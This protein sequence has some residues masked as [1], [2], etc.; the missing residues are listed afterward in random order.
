LPRAAAATLTWFDTWWKRVMLTSVFPTATAKRHCTRPVKKVASKRSC[1]IWIDVQSCVPC[2][3]YL[4]HHTTHN[5]HV[6]VMNIR[7]RLMHA[8]GSVQARYPAVGEWSLA[9][10][11][12]RVGRQGWRP[13]QEA[14][15]EVLASTSKLC[16]CEHD[17]VGKNSLQIPELQGTNR[18]NDSRLQ[19]AVCF[20]F[21]KPA[22]PLLLPRP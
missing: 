16:L 12:G 6:I 7:L 10:N 13:Q 8:R 18:I 14:V 19:N 4:H 21:T 2:F 15:G 17:Q 3:R 5:M 22:R 11:F 9:R 20:L 1:T